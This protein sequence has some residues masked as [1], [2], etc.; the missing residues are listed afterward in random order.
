MENTHVFAF[1]NCRLLVNSGSTIIPIRSCLKFHEMLHADVHCFIQG[2][3]GLGL[4]KK[5]TL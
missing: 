1:I 5:S 3:A 2:L 4:A